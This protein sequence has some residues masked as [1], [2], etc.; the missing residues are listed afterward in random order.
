MAHNKINQGHRSL[1]ADEG[2]GR[3]PRRCAKVALVALL[4]AFVFS[5]NALAQVEFVS[6]DDMSALTAPIRD[7]LPSAGIIP[8]NIHSHPAIAVAA[9]RVEEIFRRVVE[10]GEFPGKLLVLFGDDYT[11][12]ARTI[13]NP[14]KQGDTVFIINLGE[15][16][17]SH[18]DAE[19]AATICH[20]I[21]H[22]FSQ[23]QTRVDALANSQNREDRIR[24]SLLKRTIETEVDLRARQRLG[25]AGYPVEAM[26]SLWQRER[27]YEKGEFSV[28]HTAQSSRVHALQGAAVIDSRMRGA[29][30]KVREYGNS[31][32]LVD[33]IKRNLFNTPE[34]EAGQ[35][36]KIAEILKTKI[37]PAQK[38]Y[39]QIAAGKF[40][41]VANTK[42]GLFALEIAKTLGQ[43]EALGHTFLTDSER[44]DLEIKVHHKMEKWFREALDRHLRT[45][46][47]TSKQMS[48]IAALNSRYR[49]LMWVEK[50]EASPLIQHFEDKKKWQ[51]RL[52]QL[53]NIP[54]TDP[55]EQL[56]NKEEVTNILRHLKEAEEREPLFKKVFNED[57]IALAKQYQDFSRNEQEKADSDIV[58]G[59]VL[60]KRYS[61]FDQEQSRMLD[62]RKLVGALERDASLDTL[63][64]FMW[65]IDSRFKEDKFGDA[66]VRPKDIDEA[67]TLLQ[68]YFDG[69]SRNLQENPGPKARRKLLER[70]VYVSLNTFN[71]RL[72]PLLSPLLKSPQHRAPTVNALRGLVSS[73]VDTA[74]SIEEL[75][76]LFQSVRTDMEPIRGWGGS[77]QRTEVVHQGG[78]VWTPEL[79]REI[80]DPELTNRF[81]LKTQSELQRAMR[82]GNSDGVETIS[83]VLAQIGNAFSQ[84]GGRRAFI[85]EPWYKLE[86][87][88][89]NYAESELQSILKRP[90]SPL[91]AKHYAVARYPGIFELTVSA[92]RPSGTAI[93]ETLIKIQKQ[94]IDPS[95]LTGQVPLA[96]LAAKILRRDKVDHLVAELLPSLRPT[97]KSY[98]KTHDYDSL[99]PSQQFG[100]RTV[101]LLI[102]AFN[103]NPQTA[104]SSVLKALDPVNADSRVRSFD[105]QQYWQFLGEVLK[106]EANRTLGTNPSR[107]NVKAA[108]SR[109]FAA[110]RPWRLQWGLKDEHP[111]PFRDWQA[112]LTHRGPEEGAER[113]LGFM[114][115]LAEADKAGMAAG[116]RQ[117]FRVYDREKELSGRVDLKA[118]VQSISDLQESGN[119][120]PE[121]LL[122]L[123]QRYTDVAGPKSDADAVILGIIKTVPRH[124]ELAKRLLDPSL[125]E[126]CYFDATKIEVSKWQLEERFGIEGL[127]QQ[128]KARTSP[129]EKVGRR[130]IVGSV[131]RYLDHQMENHS[132]AK[133]E[134]LNWA[135]ERLLTNE[136]ETAFLEERAMGKKNWY[137]SDRLILIDAPQLLN[138]S[139]NN[140]VDRWE[141]MRYLIGDTQDVPA[142]VSR[143]YSQEENQQLLEESR[144]HFQRAGPYERA[145]LLQPLLDTHNGMLSSPGTRE[146]VIS[147]ILGP[148]AANN[149]ARTVIE[150]YIRHAPSSDGQYLLAYVLGGLT[151]KPKDAI[152]SLADVFQAAGPFGVKVA[153]ALRASGALPPNQRQQLD[154]FFDS[155]LPPTRPE[156]FEQL[157]EIFGDKLESIDSVRQVVGSGS[158][159]YVV[160]VD[161]RHPQT[162][163]TV[164]VALRVGRATTEGQ[165][166]SE[167]EIWEKVLK[168][169]S[170]STNPQLR[171]FAIVGEEIRREVMQTLGPDGDELDQRVER[172]SLKEAAKAYRYAI[173]GSNGWVVDTAEVDGRI[174]GIIPEHFQKRVSAFHF[175]DNVKIADIPDPA[176]RD[177]VNHSMLT[178][179]LR[180]IDGGVFDPEGHPGNWLVDLK[181]KRIV[182]ID[183]AKLVRFDKQE[184]ADAKALLTKM[185][186]PYFNKSEVSDLA[187][188]LLGAFDWSPMKHGPP[189]VTDIE[190]ELRRLLKHRDLPA[191]E[192]PLERIFFIRQA[193]EDKYGDGKILR[194]SRPL[195]ATVASLARTRILSERM[196]PGSYQTRLL[197]W[198]DAPIK[199]IRRRVI[200][201]KVMGLPADYC[202]RMIRMLTGK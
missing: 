126:R 161:I 119:A 8:V 197:E 181:N 15:L 52:Q 76:E 173:P 188:S 41:G 83:R 4:L 190:G 57:A 46:K 5:R 98:N 179:E 104:S 155:A 158:V 116:I 170:T 17:G 108:A 90:P 65:G 189:S 201:K 198:L 125:V 25:R 75:S 127:H 136:E 144:K 72:K 124:S 146:L 184:I 40:A 42:F 96:D 12:N 26:E 118:L 106:V 45:H 101:P 53:S 164:P 51:A 63:R 172:A 24:A 154:K 62:Q 143:G 30:Y 105:W 110:T 14:E 196:V 85:P 68:N 31:T 114:D 139:L 121:E 86:S 160:L 59:T 194:L 48:Q 81:F 147:R 78:F 186:N 66:I 113:L 47:P 77:W 1:G 157:K 10:P 39:D 74:G 64:G 178:A 140:N 13:R 191:W 18:S 20:E 128:L 130:E 107:E 168:E 54:L 50:I 166:F 34:F 32:V 9:K 159:N 115:A 135:E 16:Y 133:N 174:Q 183:L 142:F 94:A 49:E 33:D 95:R 7:G 97:D 92:D 79:A 167:N 93:V 35:R 193:M 171:R 137:L 71:G 87:D 117:S 88:I 123:V 151:G 112:N 99:R 141:L 165:V 182:R 131:R 36:R 176:L 192:D 56:R 111:N 120:R 109:I 150:S 177:F 187:K 145:Y 38:Y 132:A 195:L 22:H 84:P 19:V 122:E 21:E 61:A 149:V 185:L 60:S 28:S 67:L 169:L 202:R 163:E 2:R 91:E 73:L 156:I 103:T 23:I 6:A 129:V 37:N 138:A 58:A 134:V 80:L 100:E 180:A 82:A 69:C 29:R 3:A 162:G 199:S 200:V 43:I 148:H 55:L 102:S 27:K 44:I 175:V 152:P 153:Q 11:G 89:R 70:T